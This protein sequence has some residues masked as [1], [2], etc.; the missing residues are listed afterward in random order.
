MIF[1]AIARRC[2]GIHQG[3]VRKKGRKRRPF[4]HVQACFH[5]AL[6]LS[7]GRK[8]NDG[9]VEKNE[10]DGAKNASETIFENGG[11]AREEEK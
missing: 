8:I 4:R 9:K 5:S 11:K 1:C 7:H 2:I 6:F 3:R 10:D